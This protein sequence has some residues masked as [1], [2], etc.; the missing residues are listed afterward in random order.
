MKK[1]SL[2]SMFSLAFA[3]ASFAQTRVGGMVGY[4]SDINQWGLGA[5]A[6]FLFND[7]RMA[8]APKIMFF[9]PEKTAGIKYA[10]WEIDGDF[11]YYFV[12]DGPVGLYGIGGLN[13]TTIK[14][15]TSSAFTD[16]YDNSNSELG[17]NLG[18]GMNV[19]AGSV[20]P[21]AEVKYIAGKA[22]QAVVFAGLKIP[23]S[24]E[25]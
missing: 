16:G 3:A 4:G 19:R 5:N 10:Y 8:I 1:L 2:I 14:V 11:H 23:L 9:F 12:A 24:N 21:F 15:K 6:E 17:V 22:S 20:M 7:G 13:L 18:L 25:Y